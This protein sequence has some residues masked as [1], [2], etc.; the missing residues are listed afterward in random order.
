L[1]TWWQSHGRHDLPWQRQRTPYRVWIAEIMLQQTQVGTV[2][3]YFE[4]FMAAFPDLESLAG[5]DIDRVLAHWSGLGYYA[6]ARNLHAA[7]VRCLTDHGG[8]LPSDPEAL[9]AL[10]GIGRSTANAIV[11]QAH[12]VRAPIL[13][14]NVKRVLARHAGIE[15]WPGRSAV[16]RA[17][18]AESEARTPPDRAADYTQAVMDLGA[19][20]CTPRRP[21]CA[22]CPVTADCVARIEDR[23]ASLPGSKPRRAKPRRDAVLL[24]IENER[25]EILLERRPPTGIWGGLWSLPEAGETLDRPDGDPRRAPGPIRHQFT[26]FTLDIRFE[27]LRVPQQSGIGDDD[28]HLW[29]SPARALQLGLP[30]PVRRV[31]GELDR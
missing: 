3:P 23:I 17:L 13:D 5:A 27:R 1:L 18:W 26:H 20:V 19:T 25:G 11:A 28:N 4:R 16:A 7:A 6:R 8:E 12:D 29:C 24:I 14:G 2:I 15:G 22:Q 9:E 31:V 10:P 30:Q 21:D